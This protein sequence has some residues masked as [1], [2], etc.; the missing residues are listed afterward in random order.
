MNFF[1]L[2]K[3]EGFTPAGRR[4]NVAKHA[5]RAWL[6]E[7]RE[8]W[9]ICRIAPTHFSKLRSGAASS[10]YAAP[11]GLKFS[12]DCGATN[13]PRRWRFGGKDEGGRMNDETGRFRVLRVFRG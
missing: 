1:P 4:I 10:G 7:A 9:H 11:P 13:M 3:H 8:G 12:L 2:R 6:L 5:N